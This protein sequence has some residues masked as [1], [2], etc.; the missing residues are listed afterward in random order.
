MDVDIR[1]NSSK[2]TSVLSSARP[3]KNKDERLTCESENGC[4]QLDAMSLPL[5][6][7]HHRV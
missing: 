1:F 2:T 6:V 4:C 7:P 3:E 5:P